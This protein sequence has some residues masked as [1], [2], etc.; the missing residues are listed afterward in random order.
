MEI[1]DKTW[2]ELIGNSQIP[3]DTDLFFE[4]LKALMKGKKIDPSMTFDF[5]KNRICS[6]QTNFKSLKKGGF[7]CI[8]EMFL[9]I[10]ENVNKMFIS[11]E[12]LNG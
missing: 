10:N 4:H 11:H 3:T 12:Y 2:I 9:H 7:E 1:L 8:R 6:E 5:F